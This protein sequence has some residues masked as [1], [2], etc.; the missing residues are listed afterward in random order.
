MA[1]TH[2]I[3]GL[4]RNHNVN[5]DAILDDQKGCEVELE[6]TG[7]W[8]NNSQIR[9]QLKCDRR[10]SRMTRTRS[11]LGLTRRMA[12]TWSILGLTQSHLYESGT[13]FRVL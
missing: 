13:I 9:Q 4:T 3:F 5:S 11:I 8:G 10:N 6:V 1:I 2:S 12:R 7:L